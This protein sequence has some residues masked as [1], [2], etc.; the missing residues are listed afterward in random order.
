MFT[1]LFLA[2]TAHPLVYDYAPATTQFSKETTMAKIAPK[3]VKPIAKTK[4]P[5]AAPAE[6]VS[7]VAE[8]KEPLTMAV[9]DLT[10]RVKPSYRWI[11]GDI[12]QEAGPDG[13]ETSSLIS[14]C[15]VAAKGAGLEPKDDAYWGRR[16]TRARALLRKAGLGVFK[17]TRMEVATETKAPKAK[18]A[19][20]AKAA[21]EYEDA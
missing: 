7:E 11:A 1:K 6:D 19:S 20:K 14:A 15:H 5:K 8:P 16:L 4:A 2:L 21:P 13:A 9:G 10:R 3:S 12:V 18:K 17:A